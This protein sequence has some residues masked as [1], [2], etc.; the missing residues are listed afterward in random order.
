MA[1]YWGFSMIFNDDFEGF[2]SEKI[3][4]PEKY[5]YQDIFYSITRTCKKASKKKLK[6]NIFSFFSSKFHKNWHFGG[7]LETFLEAISPQSR[8]NHWFSL[9][10]HEKHLHADG[11]IS[12]TT[13]SWKTNSICAHSFVPRRFHFFERKK[14]TVG[15]RRRK[16]KTK[17][18]Y[19]RFFGIPGCWTP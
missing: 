18:I 13:W 11:P 15:G 5:G 8:R 17:M 16:T 4:F 9:I 3:G 14:H 1:R 12:E 10:F 2:L 19:F 7:T 6:R